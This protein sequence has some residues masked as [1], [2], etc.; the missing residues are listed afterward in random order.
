MRNSARVQILSFGRADMGQL[1]YS[2][3]IAQA[4]AQPTPQKVSS[5]KTSGSAVRVVACG[6]NHTLYPPSPLSPRPGSLQPIWRENP[7]SHE[8]I[9]GMGT[10]ALLCS[11]ARASCAPAANA[12]FSL[13]QTLRPS[14]GHLS[15]SCVLADGSVYAWGNGTS[16]QLGLGSCAPDPSPLPRPVLSE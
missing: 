14:T 2:T 7:G 8:C 5:L 15:C 11:A 1:G 4:M 16:G 13:E 10:D 3:S 9:H 6:S 12:A